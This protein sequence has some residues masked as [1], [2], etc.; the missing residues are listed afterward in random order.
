MKNLIIILLSV[1]S[2]TLN[3]QSKDYRQKEVDKKVLTFSTSFDHN[4]ICDFVDFINANFSTDIEKLRAAFT[5][6]AQ[7]FEY[8]IENMYAINFYSDPQELINAMLKNKKGACMHFAYLFNEIVIQLGI[9]TQLIF[10]YTKQRDEVNSNLHAWCAS[11]VDSTWFL[12]DPTWGSGH[13]YNQKFVRKINNFY[14]KTTPKDLIRSHM[15]FDPLWQF[16]YYPISA[17]EFYDGKISINTKR[18]FFN[19]IDTLAA[20]ENKTKIEQLISANRRI[21]KNGIKNP[22]TYNQLLNNTR[23]IEY[24]KRE[25]QYFKREIEYYKSQNVTDNYNEAVYLYNEGINQLNEFLEYRNNVFSP[26]KTETEVLKMVESAEK[27]L[28]DSQ[29]ILI[30]ITTENL[31]TKKLI[32]Q[33]TNSISNAIVQINEQKA[34]IDKYYKTPKALRKTLFYKSYS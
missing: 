15:P 22:L 9:N 12:F 23:E 4:T 10:G 26:Q 11:F 29:Y 18:E 14:F 13:I 16:S 28:L 24:Y 17:Q 2:F 30:N 34:F 5:W 6:V 20:Y 3:A 21:E 8:D 32:F 27:L 33:L 1:I 19:Y 7:N 31:S 25:M